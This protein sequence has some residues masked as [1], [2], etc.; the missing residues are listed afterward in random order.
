MAHKPRRDE[1]TT[2]SIYLTV[3]TTIFLIGL[4]AG[5]A[6][7]QGRGRGNAMHI[8]LPI[9]RSDRNRMIRTPQIY[10]TS[11]VRS[12]RGRGHH[13]GWVHKKYAYGY[14]NYGHYRR[15]QVGNRRYRTLRRP[16]WADRRRVPPLPNK[17]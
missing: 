17:F 5:S 6:F 14:R 15:T 11:R 4:T 9:V 3:V 1:M 12:W 2:K 10:S 16:S 13:Y 8:G 7:G